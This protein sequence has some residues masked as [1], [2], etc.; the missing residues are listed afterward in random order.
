MDL[1]HLHPDHGDPLLLTR[2]LGGAREFGTV[3][4]LFAQ[5]S[6]PTR[7]RIFW[8]LCHCE[9]CVTNIAA[10]LDMSS[11]AVSHHL[12]SLRET[13]LIVSRRVGREVFYCAAES[14][15]A[16]LLHHVIEQVMSITCPEEGRRLSEFRS[17]QL[18]LIQQVHDYL[19]QHLDERSTIEDLSREFHMNPTTLKAVFKS[20]YGNSLAAHI[21]EHRMEKAAGLLRG[22]DLSI[23]EVARQV[24]YDSQSKFST[25]FR[26]AYG[27]LPKEYRRKRKVPVEESTDREE[28][29]DD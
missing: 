13:G 9:E 16:D 12:R 22:T 2:A 23:L 8:L 28:A 18:S 15:T 1:P 10:L 17:D 11:P 20:V 3:S 27:L 19:V 4:E 7:I 24:G 5:L 25:A 26:E 14:E 29:C 6:D 21:K